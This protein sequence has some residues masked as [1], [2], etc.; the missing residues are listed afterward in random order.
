MP[1]DSKNPEYDKFAF[2]WQKCRDAV[3]GED[4]VK[5]G[6]QIYLPQL[7]GQT[8]YDYQ[9]YKNRALYFSASG[10]TVKGLAGAILRKHPVIQFPNEDLLLTIGPA[11]E[12]LE[13]MIKTIVEE[14]ITTGRVGVLV[15]SAAGPDN[16]NVE[17]YLAIYYPENIINWDERTVAGRRQ[18][19]MVVLQESG[20]RRDDD[21]NDPFAWNSRVDTYRVM[22]LIGWDTPNPFLRVS[23][24]ERVQSSDENPTDQTKENEDE[25]GYKGFELIDQVEPKLPGGIPIDYIPFVIINPSV[26]GSECE[27]PPIIDLVNVNL[28]HYRNSADLEHGLHFTALPQPWVAGVESPNIRLRIGSQTA[29]VIADPQARAGYLEFSGN[30]LRAIQAAMDEKKKMMAILGS[31]LLEDQKADAEAAATVKLRHSGDESVLANIVHAIDEGLAL[32]LMWFA[33]WA[34]LDGEI[35][36]ELND[37]FNP[38]GIDYPT[39]IGLMSAVQAG[40]LSWDTWFYNVK[41]GEL[42]PDGR[43]AEQEKALIEAG[44]PVLPTPDIS[45]D[46]AVGGGKVKSG[47]AARMSGANDTGDVGPS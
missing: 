30:G 10:R 28:S 45:E 24:Y 34:M 2:Q 3:A 39:L 23:L 31:R 46:T 9:A 15:D 27:P 1:I 40:Q 20:P 7:E 19:V 16:Q 42:V 26:A 11:G 37:D 5:A 41:R 44:Y 32:S 17:P 38:L 29:W 21:G 36:V 12:S 47:G 6:N 33:Q 35:T 14:V 25:D 43:T 13:H 4:A 18:L 22:E 8:D